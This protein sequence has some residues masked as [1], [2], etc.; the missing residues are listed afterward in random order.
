MSLRGRCLGRRSNSC[1]GCSSGGHIA[2]RP[3]CW[4]LTRSDGGRIPGL[5]VLL[6]PDPV[7]LVLDMVMDGGRVR[8][9]GE[10]RREEG[11]RRRGRYKGG[12]GREGSVD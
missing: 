4:S 6:G 8:R 7:G 9:K 2:A 3:Q 5:P 10:Q 11:E 12:G 1:R